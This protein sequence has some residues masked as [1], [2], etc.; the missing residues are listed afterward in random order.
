MPL[1]GRVLEDLELI[2]RMDSCSFETSFDEL[3]GDGGLA[4]GL[5]HLDEV[6][7]ADRFKERV[8]AEKVFLTL[9]DSSIKFRENCNIQS[10][11]KMCE[12]AGECHRTARM[13]GG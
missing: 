9:T 7:D 13:K 4:A 3:W 1:N 11:Q 8:R 12:V 5:S 6:G 10:R 2:V